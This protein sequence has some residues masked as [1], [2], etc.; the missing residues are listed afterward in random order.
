MPTGHWT[1][2]RRAKPAHLRE[3]CRRPPRQPKLGTDTDLYHD[4]SLRPTRIS[5]TLCYICLQYTT[6]PSESDGQPNLL[7][8]RTVSFSL[9]IVFWHSTSFP[10]CQGMNRPSRH[11]QRVNSP[12]PKPSLLLA[13]TASARLR[14]KRRHDVLI[15]ERSNDS[16]C[17]GEPVGSMQALIRTRWVT[18]Q[19]AYS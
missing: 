10:F 12:W 13:C 9:F 6:L 1:G 16:C 17:W 19:C 18:L 7:L 2:G 5:S 11:S 4:N 14:R 8:T 15:M 3:G